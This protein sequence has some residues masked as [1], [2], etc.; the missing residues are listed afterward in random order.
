[1]SA[2]Q[3][4]LLPKF[5]EEFNQSSIISKKNP[6][7]EKYRKSFSKFLSAKSI[8]ETTVITKYLVSKTVGEFC[9]IEL[10]DVQLLKYFENNYY[11]WH[12]DGANKNELD[13]VRIMTMSINLNDDYSGGGLELDYK[14][15]IFSQEKVPGAYCIFPSFCRHRA[16]TVTEGVRKAATFWFLG[17]EEN[18]KLL[19]NAY[20]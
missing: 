16:L 6:Y 13:K 19:T 9:L 14:G 5:S 8:P 18:L 10:P 2:I 3:K 15:E 12:D 17:T 1:M 7:D 4:E 11:H 20:K